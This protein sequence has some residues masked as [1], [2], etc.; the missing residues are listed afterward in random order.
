[1]VE[2]DG[3]EPPFPVLMTGVLSILDDLSIKEHASF[4]SEN[5][6]SDGT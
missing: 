3:F 2:K 5:F 4:I 6:F 1:M